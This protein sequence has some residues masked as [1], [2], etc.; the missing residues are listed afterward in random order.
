MREFV[1]AENRTEFLRPN[2]E[3][4]IVNREDAKDGLLQRPL[5]PIII[6][7]ELVVLQELR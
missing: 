7:N 6:Y 2:V 4:L 3:G 1:I 5:R